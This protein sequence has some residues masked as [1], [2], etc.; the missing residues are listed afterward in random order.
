ME[1]FYV[2]L[3]GSPYFIILLSSINVL[4]VLLIL[5]RARAYLNNKLV[6]AYFR[7]EEFGPFLRFSLLST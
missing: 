2:R 1:V 5:S 7:R 6:L 3:F 4:I